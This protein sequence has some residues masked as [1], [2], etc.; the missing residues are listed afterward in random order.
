MCEN[1]C[2]HDLYDSRNENKVQPWNVAEGQI[3][4]QTKKFFFLKPNYLKLNGFSKK[5][6]LQGFMQRLEDYL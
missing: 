3:L 2:S 5:K 4:I 6:H 1:L